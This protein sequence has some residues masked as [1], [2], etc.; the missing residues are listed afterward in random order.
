MPKTFLVLQILSNQ[1]GSSIRGHSVIHNVQGI[2]IIAPPECSL[3][4]IR[5]FCKELAAGSAK[6][7]AA[8]FKQPRPP[9]AR[10]KI[11]PSTFPRRWAPH[12]EVVNE[13]KEKEDKNNEKKE[14]GKAETTDPGLLRFSSFCSHP[15]LVTL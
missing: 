7:C 4:T 14:D 9:A 12:D 13:E 1:D 8:W 10:S 3:L 15:V 6:D 2:T 11:G 5:S